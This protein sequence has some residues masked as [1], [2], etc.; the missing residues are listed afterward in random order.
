MRSL[1]LETVHDVNTPTSV[2]SLSEVGEKDQER[3][4]AAALTDILWGAGEERSAMVSL[5][6]SDYCITPHL[7]YKQ[8]GRASC[9]E[10]V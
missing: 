6:T 9:R 1:S 10:R 5:V 2:S 8:I 7:D 4:L 3:A